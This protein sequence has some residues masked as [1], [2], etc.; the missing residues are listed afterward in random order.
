MKIWGRKVKVIGVVRSYHLCRLHLSTAGSTMVTE[1]KMDMHME[2][3]MEM[4]MNTNTNNEVGS[5]GAL[6]ANTIKLGL[7]RIM[8]S[9]FL[10]ID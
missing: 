6:S 4:Y 3:E 1:I 8:S 10:S 5:G 9:A 2:M 7:V